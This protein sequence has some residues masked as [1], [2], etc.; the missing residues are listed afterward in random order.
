MPPNTLQPTLLRRDANNDGPSTGLIVGVVCGALGGLIALLF[1]IRAMV[2][3]H[4]FRP[5]PAPLPPVQELAH[6]RAAELVATAKARA[7]T[8]QQEWHEHQ[9]SQKRA[10]P[11]PASD[12]SAVSLVRAETATPTTQEHGS[13]LSREPSDGPF[14]PLP[15]PQLPFVMRRQSQSTTSDT[16]VP[17]SPGFSAPSHVSSVVTFHPPQPSSSTTSLS[18][19][20]SRSRPPQPSASRAHSTNSSVSKGTGRSRGAPHSRRSTMQI[21]LPAPL[22]PQI[23]NWSSV[24]TTSANSSSS[25]D[26]RTRRY[27]S[28]SSHSHAT[29]VDSWVHAS[30]RSK[31][32]ERVDSSGGMSHS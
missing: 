15:A 13:F 27:S 18:A 3:M 23:S 30:G 20:R 4:I 24:T 17:A 29:N 31:S 8:S 11:Y 12:G 25:P 28:G 1:L 5:A 22:A 26:K 14:I 6:H 21:I 19:H 16:S 9:A 7:A 32:R 10:R 2:R